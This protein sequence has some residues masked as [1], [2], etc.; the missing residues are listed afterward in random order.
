[1]E[2]FLVFLQKSPLHMVLLATAVITGGMLVWPLVTRLT[3]PQKEVSALEAVQLINR[4]DAVVVD[5]READE[6]QKGHIAN[7]RHIPVAHVAER[8]KELEK[9]KTKPIIV[10]CNSGT[11]SAS[12]IGVLTKNGFS[13][14]YG[15]RGGVSAWQQAS[16]PLEK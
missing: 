7:S 1:M 4:R 5:V 3:R 2:S 14:V 13:E 8:L 12:V 6:Y 16:M 15:L 11:R 9:Y 10:T